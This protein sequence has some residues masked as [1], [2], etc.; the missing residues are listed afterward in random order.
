MKNIVYILLLVFFGVTFV[1]CEKDT[2]TEDHSVITYYVDIQLEGDETMVIPMGSDYQDP[3]YI[4]L[5]NEKEV[6]N[7]VEVQG[8]VNPDQVGFYP[9]KY[10]AVNVDG[11]PT[12]VTRSVIVYDP[13]A[14]PVDLSGTYNGNYAQ[15][16]FGKATLTKLANGFY[17]VSDFFA[18]I[19]IYDFEYPSAYVAAGYMQINPDN[20]IEGLGITS[21]WG[22]EELITGS[23]DPATQTFNYQLAGYGGWFQLVKE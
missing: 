8:E 16:Y 15:V 19:Y 11:F 6:T 2:S 10:K 14:S 4:A 3:G 5:E 18:G 21:P 20:T 23:Y 22:V 13:N 17:R 7:K 9:I 12:E 1:S